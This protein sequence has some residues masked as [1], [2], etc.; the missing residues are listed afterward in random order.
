MGVKMLLLISNLVKALAAFLYRT[1]KR[2]L[3][4]VNSQMI[5]KSLRLLE[6]LSASR[7]IT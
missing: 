2:F 3:T 5:E 7:V 4:G 1:D 6:K